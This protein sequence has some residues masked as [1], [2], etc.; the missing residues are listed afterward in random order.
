V[1]LLQVFGLLGCQLISL[2]CCC[3]VQVVDVRFEGPL[4][5]VLGPPLV[6]LGADA[7]RLPEFG[8]KCGVVPSV[9]LLCDR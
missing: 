9:S 8:D 6:T 4:R 5:R 1:K 7:D 3:I 2:C